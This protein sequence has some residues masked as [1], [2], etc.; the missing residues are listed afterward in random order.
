MAG[1]RIIQNNITKMLRPLKDSDWAGLHDG[2]MPKT[3]IISDSM[4]LIALSLSC[5]ILYEIGHH[6]SHPCQD[7]FEVRE[8]FLK[9]AREREM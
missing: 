3:I 8:K 9:G 6:D 5:A 1:S 2:P 7:Y 4:C